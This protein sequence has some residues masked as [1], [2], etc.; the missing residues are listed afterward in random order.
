VLAILFLNR[1]GQTVKCANYTVLYGKSGI[2][3]S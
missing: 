2:V 3:C 1:L